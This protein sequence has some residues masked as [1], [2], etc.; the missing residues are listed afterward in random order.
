MNKLILAASIATAFS[1]ILHATAADKATQSKEQGVQFVVGAKDGPKP[2]PDQPISGKCLTWMCGAKD[3]QLTG[4][5]VN[6]VIAQPIG[7]VTL[8]SSETIDLSSQ[9]TSVAHPMHLAG[10]VEDRDKILTNE[11]QQTTSSGTKRRRR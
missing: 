11:Q 3:R 5:E 7:G 6:V 9:A 4:I 1:F 10:K 2:R 8:P